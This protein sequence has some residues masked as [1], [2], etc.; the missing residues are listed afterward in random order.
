M[1]LAEWA[2]STK[3]APATAGGGSQGFPVECPAKNGSGQLELGHAKPLHAAAEVIA[4]LLAD[5]I[6]VF[7]PEARL[8]KCEGKT[9]AVSRLWGKNSIDIQKFRNDFSNDYA[10]EPFQAAL[11]HAS[12]L[13]P[14]HAWLGTGDLKDAHVLV[15]PGPQPFTYEIASID[16]ADAFSWDASGGNPVAPSAQ[17]VLALDQHR[18]PQRMSAIIANIEGITEQRI[19]ELVQQVPDDVLLSG[20]KDR[21]VAGLVAR[22][23]KVRSALKAVGWL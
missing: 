20:D 9:M 4:S 10:S 5:E 6:G 8:G 2:R 23:G 12:G 15:R 7:V 21:Y 1:E 19:R 3:W 17:F 16:F 18:D 11:R 13:L 14:F 22:K